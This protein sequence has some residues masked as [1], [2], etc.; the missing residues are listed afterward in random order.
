MSS[1]QLK[2]AQNYQNLEVLD[3]GKFGAL[4]KILVHEDQRTYALKEISLSHHKEADK[5]KALKDAKI[6]YQLLK[7][8]IPN[9]I[10]SIGSIYDDK[11]EAFLYSMNY[12]GMNLS[13]L[14]KNRKKL[15]FEEFVPIFADILTG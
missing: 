6:Q 8:G 10:K 1:P 15:K 13:Q 4:Y 7:K 2:S 14:V 9:V 3:S 5:T 12:N 11:K